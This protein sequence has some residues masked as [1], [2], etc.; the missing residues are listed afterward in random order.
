MIKIKKMFRRHKCQVGGSIYK[1][2]KKKKKK[3]KRQKLRRYLKIKK[4]FRQYLMMPARAPQRYR[5]AWNVCWL[6][7]YFFFLASFCRVFIYLFNGGCN[8]FDC[9]STGCPG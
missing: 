3:K 1:F 4:S 6:L 8:F 5:F 7:N 9:F 2:K